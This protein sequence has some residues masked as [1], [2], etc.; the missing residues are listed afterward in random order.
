MTEERDQGIRTDRMGV[1]AKQWK[2]SRRGDGGK[3]WPGSLLGL[4]KVGRFQLQSWSAQTLL[5]GKLGERTSTSLDKQWKA[6]DSSLS[7]AP[8][9]L[10]PGVQG[11]PQAP[12]QSFSIRST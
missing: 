7:W 1:K 5:E 6:M 3:A 4:W 2:D 11:C 8:A 9:V 12:L 10:P